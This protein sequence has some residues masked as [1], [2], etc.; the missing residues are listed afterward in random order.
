LLAGVCWSAQDRIIAIVNKDAVTQKDL[1]EF[2]GVMYMQMESELGPQEAEARINQMKAEF[3]EKLVE[4]RLVLQEARKQ[5][6]QV[7][8]SRVKSKIAKIRKE[9]NSEA[10]FQEAVQSRGMVQADLENR[11]RDQLL[12][13][14]VVEK[15]VR[16]KISVLP[17][18]VTAYYT[19]HP[20]EFMLPEEREFRTLSTTNTVLAAT[21]QERLAQHTATLEDL[22]QSSGIAL[23]RIVFAQDNKLNPDVAKV[24][25]A[26][27]PGEVS[28]LLQIKDTAY[29]FR[30]EQ[31][32]PAHQA[33][34][35]EMRGK[36][37]AYLMDDKAQKALV[38]WMDKLKK[39][40]YIKF[41]E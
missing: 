6:L 20:Q 15:E 9:Y 32:L 21:F 4:D 22:A 24:L 38:A 26:L 12:S 29:F 13:M 8:E 34:L 5:N 2:A 3:V 17:T 23:N 19:A 33:S 1:E 11:I 30:L 36:I 7:N 10:A 39:Q 40:A 41:N 14:A 27:E 18:E 28:K 37:Y 35:E 16:S 31:V 25:F